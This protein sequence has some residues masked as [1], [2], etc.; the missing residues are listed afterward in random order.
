[1]SVPAGQRLPCL[2]GALYGKVHPME[3]RRPLS[4][5]QAR[6][7]AD[8]AAHWLA[9]DGRVRLVYQFGSSVD[10]ARAAVRDVDIAILTDPPLPLDAL[11]RLRAD[12]V[13][14]TG[15]P[16]DLVSLNDAS[17]VLAWEVADSGR[18]LYARDADT[19]TDF[20]TRVR[21]RYWDF[22]PF[23]DE[24]WRLAGERL[25]ERRRGSQA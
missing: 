11:L 13:V 6:Q 18:C 25:E 10:S 9:N 16:I 23:L 24:Q 19:D 15:A 4:T 7:A 1:M 21:A 2:A 12:L 14:E 17:V 8:R 22:K 20:V 3:Q 5:E